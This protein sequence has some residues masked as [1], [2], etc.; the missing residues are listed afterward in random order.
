MI[1]ADI[2]GC[3]SSRSTTSMWPPVH[4]GNSVFCAEASSRVGS[5]P[6]SSSSRMHSRF[7]LKPHVCNAVRSVESAVLTSAPA[8]TRS[9]AAARL[10][11]ATAHTS[12]VHPLLSL[13]STFCPPYPPSSRIS[14]IATSS[15][16]SAKCSG[17][18]PSSSSTS[19]IAPALIRVA[20]KATL[21]S[22]AAQCKGVRPDLSRA[23]T[24]TPFESSNSFANSSLS[25][26][27]QKWSAVLPI[28]SV[29]LITSL[30]AAARSILTHARL[31]SAAAQCK[32]VFPSTSSWARGSAPALSKSI[33]ISAES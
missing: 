26:A 9:L 20:A 33:H 31:S 8:A 25:S 17:V 29:S 7:P 27:M 11:C 28:L 12:G 4:G 13:R 14:T 30:S 6:L 3:S 15:C 2:P 22:A 16:W 21:F 23:S 32:G 5:A 24:S 19:V 10:P 1:V 18:A